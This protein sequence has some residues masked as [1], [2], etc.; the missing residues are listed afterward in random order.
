MARLL[1]IIIGFLLF[2][3]GEWKGYAQTLSV[4]SVIEEKNNVIG[5]AETRLDLNNQPCALLKIVMPCAISRVEGNFIGK[6][7]S[8]NG[9]QWVYVTGG[10]NRIDIIPDGFLPVSINFTK[11]GIKRL[12]GGIV[13]KVKLVEQVEGEDWTAEELFGMAQACYE[14]K[15]YQQAYRWSRQSAKK[16]SAAALNLVG[17]LYVR[18]L[19]LEKNEEKAFICFKQA[20]DAGYVPAFMLVGYSYFEGRGIPADTTLAVDWFRKAMEK[21]DAS[22]YGKMA[23][24]FEKGIGM[25]KDERKAFELMTQSADKGD[26]NSMLYLAKYYEMGIGIEPDHQAALRQLRKAKV[27]GAREATVMLDK[28][29]EEEFK[30]RYS[31]TQELFLEIWDNL[32]EN[33]EK[34]YSD[35]EDRLDI[36]FIA[37][38]QNGC[39]IKHTSGSS[40]TYKLSGCATRGVYWEGFH[41]I[42][43]DETHKSITDRRTGKDFFPMRTQPQLS[44]DGKRMA[45]LDE[46]ILSISVCVVN[47][48]TGVMQTIDLMAMKTDSLLHKY[49]EAV[50][51]LNDD[52][53]CLSS[54]RGTF[55]YSLTTE[56]LT[57]LEGINGYVLPSADGKTL[58]ME[59][60]E[61]SVYYKPEGQKI[62][63]FFAL[64][65]S[66]ITL[67]GDYLYFSRCPIGGNSEIW[68]LNVNTKEEEL[69]LSSKEHGFSSPHVSPDGQYIAVT[70]NALSSTS[71]EQNL[72]IF[73]AR[74]DGSGLRQMTDH[75]G[76]DE[77]PIWSA[78]GTKLYFISERRTDGTKWSKNS[79]GWLYSMDVKAGM[80]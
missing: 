79:R 41:F 55:C 22:A 57:L 12:K 63:L 39:V 71:K 5:R 37:K 49:I 45:F 19:G 59:T 21:D 35:L 72:D 30:Q 18:G 78:D 53:L 11:Y 17:L 70:G 48:I 4:E 54:A 47:V 60:Y 40:F 36:R 68:R 31:T 76:S 51:W 13:Y 74:I 24:L 44:P 25:E 6:P 61:N 46:S 1:F 65:A 62:P 50:S 64:N 32:V 20:A 16:G 43:D 27:A 14:Q 7:I 10:S 73:I 34:N 9:E 15:D 56:T 67:H 23:T 66:D 42:Y 80:K 38:G 28:L 8:K 2:G 52:E 58:Y 29:A 26:W 69:V 75:P 33:A 77:S 3:L